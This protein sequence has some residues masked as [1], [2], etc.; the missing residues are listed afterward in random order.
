VILVDAYNVL[1]VQGVLPPRLAGI[2]IPD[3]IR[4]IRRSRHA[5]RA[6]TV[7]ADGGPGGASGT[8][9]IDGSLVRYSGSHSEA[10]AIIESML[11]RASAARTWL[12]V[13]SDRRVQRAARRARAHVLDSR[14]FLEQLVADESH[15]RGP[16]MPAFATEVPLDRASVA[17]WME[18]FGF[19]ASDLTREPPPRREMNPPPVQ[20]SRA[21]VMPTPG[22]TS[23][24]AGAKPIPSLEQPTPIAP[25]I[26]DPVL[27][28][29]AQD[30]ASRLV[31]GEL[32]MARWL[33]NEVST[34][35]AP[36]RPDRK[37]KGSR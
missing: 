22:A 21:G 5:G 29:A 20:K 34:P 16:G 12:V 18:E 8:Q 9:T 2:E 3:L 35:R 23:G 7:V 13:S 15:R 10:D 19:D 1:N 25:A 26:T 14:V 11:D 33:P 32:D 31:L 24:R 17:H 36:T 37:R 6:L 4:L 27:L 30:P 28:R